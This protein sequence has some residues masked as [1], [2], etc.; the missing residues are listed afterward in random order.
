[1]HRYTFNDV[2]YWLI[3]QQQDFYNRIGFYHQN[4]FDLVEYLFE[5]AELSSAEDVE[6]VSFSSD[7][8]DMIFTIAWL[9][10][11]HELRVKENP[12]LEADILLP[13]SLDSLGNDHLWAEERLSVARQMILE[14]LV[15]LEE[16]EM[17]LK[18]RK[19]NKK[20]SSCLLRLR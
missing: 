19:D 9:L 18:K 10:Y 1:M 11:Q 17:R 14:H 15:N 7:P 12:Q 2:K 3:E 20:R 8:T 6:L 4:S 13:Q 5:A 16:V